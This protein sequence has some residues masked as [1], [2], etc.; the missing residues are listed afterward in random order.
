MTRRLI[1][2]CLALL[3]GGCALGPNY[4]RPQVPTPPTWRDIPV[5][6]AASLA[7][8]GWWTLFD[9]PQLQELVRVLHGIDPGRY[10]LQLRDRRRRGRRSVRLLH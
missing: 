3:A 5:A 4:E 1:V 7:N 10:L 6:E 2:V 9:D 8:T